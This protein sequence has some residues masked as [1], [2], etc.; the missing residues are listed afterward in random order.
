MSAEAP[1]GHFPRHVAIIM[2]GNGRWAKGRGWP[3]TRGHLEGVKSVREITTECAR[4]G[5]QQLTLYAFSAENWRRPRSEVEFLMQ[6]LAR[7]LMQERKTLM[8]NNIRLESIGRIHELPENVQEELARSEGMS[9]ENTGMILRLALNYGGT[10]EILDAVKEMARDVSE[11]RL[12]PDAVDEQV[13][14]TYLY[15]PNMPEPDLL[16]RTGGEMRVSNFLLWH[17]SYTELYITPTYWPNF[18]KGNLEEALRT[19]ATRERRFGGLRSTSESP[20]ATAAS[21]SG[22]PAHGRYA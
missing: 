8:D 9:R 14:R 1:E 20:E 10:V 5:L 11:G 6:L 7:Y 2:D 16:I 22:T 21:P 15:D 12:A 17:I 19:Y 13:F 18:R 4:K 3:R